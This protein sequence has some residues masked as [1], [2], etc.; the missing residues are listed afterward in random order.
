[1]TKPGPKC[2]FAPMPLSH[3]VN[4]STLL[5]ALCAT[6]IPTQA[7]NARKP[8]LSGTWRLNTEDSK[9]VKGAP[10]QAEIVEIV[11]SGS[12]VTITLTVGGKQTTHSYVA[13]GKEKIERA[14]SGAP[15]ASQIVSK[16]SWID[17]GL[18]TE[19]IIRLINPLIGNVEIEHS[20]E[21]WTLSSDGNA[22]TRVTESK[23]FPEETLR[24]DKQ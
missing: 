5:I 1:M 18:A 23:N 8:D 9:I 24:Y 15:S 6:A 3:A 14:P 21:T 4:L 17:T 22:L 2:R 16:A 11:E 19:L 20:K 13:N 7:Q 10:P 12:S